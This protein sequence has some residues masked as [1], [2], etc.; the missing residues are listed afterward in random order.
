M[1]EHR[2][3]MTV[4]RSRDDEF[5]AVEV[6]FTM[7]QQE[8]RDIAGHVPIAGVVTD[9]IANG[10]VWNLTYLAEEPFRATP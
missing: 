8:W 5:V 7:S 2:L 1:P 3:S 6:K 9:A 4:D 10:K